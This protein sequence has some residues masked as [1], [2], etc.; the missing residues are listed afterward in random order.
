MALS[1]QPPP[2]TRAQLAELAALHEPAGRRAAGQLLVE[3]PTLLAEA[4]AAGL[5]PVLVAVEERP[6]AAAAAVAEQARA[7]GAA[8]VSLDARAAA[9]LSD[10]EHAPGLLAAV[11]QPRRWDG[12]L[13]GSGPALLVALCGLQDPGNV[14]TLLR[15]ARAFGAT[16]VLLTEGSAEA[17]GPKVVRA[18]AG[19]ALWLPTAEAELASLPALAARHALTLAAAEPPRAGAR[20]A[21]WDPP[22]RCLLLLGHETR[23]VPDLP[24]AVPARVAH[25]PQ[26]ESLNVAMAG[27]I[28]L[29]DWYRK[30]HA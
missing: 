13:A 4:L 25:E 14:G 24:Q 16:A 2:A 21:P 11:P 12:A 30:Q 20:A 3:G 7:A 28:L 10:R 5:R 27:S 8:L 19:A 29:A 1:S 18:S 9:R 15:S 26:V 6:P 17:F 23:G 22:P